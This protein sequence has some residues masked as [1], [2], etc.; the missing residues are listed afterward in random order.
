[1]NTPPV[2]IVSGG[3]GASGEQL[4]R[5]A[6]AQFNSANVPIRI[7]PHVKTVGQL[8][9]VVKEA[10]S[11]GGFIVHTLVD[12]QLRIA[13]IEMARNR[14][15]VAIDAIGQVLTTLA[16][17]LGQSPLGQ[18]GL[19]RQ[20]REEQFRR[21]EAINFTIRHDDGLNA[22]ELGDAEIVLLGVSRVG[23]TPLSMY[24]STR[25]WKVANVPLIVDVTPPQELFEIDP[26]RVVGLTADPAVLLMWR[27]HRQSGLGLSRGS[28][29]TDP[30]ALQDE[31]DF[32]M[33]LYRQ[34]QFSVVNVTDKPIEEC[35][36]EIIGNVT[37]RL[38]E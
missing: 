26:R 27:L 31:I 13:L 20:M 34:R 5:T 11:T 15:V 25:G 16:H 29:Y 37:R 14:N 10:M 33:R 8:D 36:D 9:A 4:V 24:L 3:V 7:V 1:M 38:N 30:D 22:K 23:K 12:L 35:S 32:A 6:L 2:F 28:S 17:M 18:P 19:Y 21:I